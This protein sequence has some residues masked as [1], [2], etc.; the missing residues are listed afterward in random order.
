MIMTISL[1]QGCM[2]LHLDLLYGKKALSQLKYV[3]KIP[4]CKISSC[5]D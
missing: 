2:L 4:N 5:C 1:V 3:I